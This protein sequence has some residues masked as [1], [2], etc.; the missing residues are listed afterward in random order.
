MRQHGSGQR[1]GREV[2]QD[3]GSQLFGEYETGAGQGFAGKSSQ[4]E[5]DVA[6]RTGDVV[7]KDD[8]ELFLCAVERYI[9]RL[10]EAHV[11]L[12]VEPALPRPLAGEPEQLPV[13]PR[14]ALLT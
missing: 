2:G 8:L 13:A 1:C 6:W 3:L 11:V 9:D 14:A 5:R 7:G 12:G 10:V 4:D